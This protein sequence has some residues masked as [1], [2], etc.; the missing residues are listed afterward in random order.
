M[1]TVLVTGASSGIGA[2]LA[3]TLA[4]RGDTLGLVGRRADR[5]ADVLADCTATS[6]SS[7]SWTLDLLDL[8]AAERLALE[9]WDTLGPIDV[10]VNNAGSPKR[11]AAA[12]LT[13]ADVE[14]TMAVNLFAPVRMTLALL[15]RM[16]DRGLGTIVNVSSVGGRVGIA[17]E[18]AYNASKFALCGW[19]E[20]LAIDLHGSGVAVR[21]I[22]P[23]PIDTDIWDRPG[24]EPAIYD[25]PLEPPQVVA[26]GIVAA[27]AGERFE[28]YLPDLSGVV[29]LKN[30]DV[31]AWIRLSAER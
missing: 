5:L 25:G 16:L 2:A 19:S 9:A 10:L 12:D 28:H 29:A 17:H 8:D 30:A 18:A 6:P 20:G 31:D 13:P 1:A 7:R 3:R 24:E 4:A 21:L 26:D 14:S 23:G 27:I 11:R 22:Q 15:P